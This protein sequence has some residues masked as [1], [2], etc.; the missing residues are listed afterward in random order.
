MWLRNEA[1]AEEGGRRP[2]KRSAKKLL[3]IN[4]GQKALAH[5]SL[6]PLSAWRG[7]FGGGFGSLGLGVGQFGSA[8]FGVSLGL[9]GACL[10][11]LIDESH[12]SQ[13]T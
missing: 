7:G 10:I 5:P 3:F 12:L 8:R 13:Y 11:A 4:R 1:G 9:A 2:K 6:L